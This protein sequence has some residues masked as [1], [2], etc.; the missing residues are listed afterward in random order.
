MENL[1]YCKNCKF[2]VCTNDQWICTL[3]YCLYGDP[4]Y[5][6][7]LRHHETKE[8]GY[9]AWGVKREQIKE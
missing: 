2:A 9:C 8:Y 6:E 7:S 3:F 1:V 4:I 5:F